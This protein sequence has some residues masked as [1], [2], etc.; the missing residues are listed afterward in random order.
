MP[1]HLLDR[2]S[3]LNCIKDEMAKQAIQELH[4]DKLPKLCFFPLEPLAASVGGAKITAD[5]GPRIWF[6]AHQQLAC[7]H[8]QK[9]GVLDTQ[10]FD[11]VHWEALYVAFH[12]VSR[13]FQVWAS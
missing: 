6:W 2:P 13:M 10:A 12:K 9:W 1:F 8:F 11:K 4:P 7:A 5:S 3:Q